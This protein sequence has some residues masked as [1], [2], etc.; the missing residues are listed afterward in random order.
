MILKHQGIGY[1][2]PCNNMKTL[3]QVT[4]IWGRIIRGFQNFTA[5]ETWLPK[6]LSNVLMPYVPVLKINRD[7]SL[8]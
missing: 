1:E 7:H 6:D 2:S 3:I 5:H 8:R 4:I